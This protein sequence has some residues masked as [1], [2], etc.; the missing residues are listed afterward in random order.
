MEDKNKITEPNQ[1]SKYVE[2]SNRTFFK[3]SLLV[4]KDL[5]TFLPKNAHEMADDLVES[6]FKVVQIFCALILCLGLIVLFPISVPIV[7]FYRGKRRKESLVRY[8]ER[9]KNFFN[10][11]P[12]KLA[13][14]SKKGDGNGN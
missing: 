5:F 7:T 11:H 2:L 6:F 4:T 9:N 10:S 12:E 14:R 13:S 1:Y 8:E 3:E